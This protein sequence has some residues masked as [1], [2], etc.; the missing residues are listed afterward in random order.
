MANIDLEDVLLHSH[1]IEIV[2]VEACP[3]C[4]GHSHPAHPGRRCNM[5]V[6]YLGVVQ[7]YCVMK[8]EPA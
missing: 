1:A 5:P 7:C 2:P 6:G 4:Y 3:K 8:K